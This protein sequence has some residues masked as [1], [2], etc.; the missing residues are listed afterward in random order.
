M[1]HL[2]ECSHLKKCSNNLCYESGCSNWLF[3][4]FSWK[5]FKANNNKKV[6]GKPHRQYF[7]V[8]LGDKYNLQTPKYVERLLKC[9]ISD[10]N[11]KK[12]K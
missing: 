8:K 4:L 3:P 10:R 7:L 5:S 12:I 2:K 9:L 6:E 1:M 11:H